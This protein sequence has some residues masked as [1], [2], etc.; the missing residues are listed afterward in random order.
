ME[1]DAPIGGRFI[2][3]ADVAKVRARPAFSDRSLI[4]RAVRFANG[5]VAS[6]RA[7]IEGCDWPP[8]SES[9]AAGPFGA[10]EREAL[11]A[12]LGAIVDGKVPAWLPAIWRRHSQS[13]ALIPASATEYHY[14]VLEYFAKTPSPPLARALVLLHEQPLGRD[15]CRCEV[16]GR[17][18]FVI[19]HARGMPRRK[20]C[21]D[22][23]MHAAHDAGASERVKR[24]RRQT[25]SKKHK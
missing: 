3:P 13:L 18:F 23:C 12:A 11:K 17:F 4:D 21:S 14:L 25:A 16:C 24:A 20:Y 1:T 22:K 9:D 19:K 5:S 7:L 8:S 2:E 10:E 6:Y 15:L